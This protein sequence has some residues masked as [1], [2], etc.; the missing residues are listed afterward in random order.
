MLGRSQRNQSAP[1]RAGSV[2]L[3]RDRSMVN[4]AGSRAG[5]TSGQ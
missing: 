1:A 3:L 5:Q 4:V 2:M